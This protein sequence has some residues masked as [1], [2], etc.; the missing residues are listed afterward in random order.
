MPNV[1]WL[2][3]WRTLLSN[4]GVHIGLRIAAAAALAAVACPLIASAIRHG[5]FPRDAG[6]A[7]SQAYSWWLSGAFV[8]EPICCLVGIS[9]SAAVVRA[10]LHGDAE[11]VSTGLGDARLK[12]GSEAVRASDTWG[13]QSAPKGTGLVYGFSHGKYLFEARSPH[14][15]TVATSGAGKTRRLVAETIDLCAAAS[16]TL[17]VSD[18]KG[19][20]F[21]LMGEGLRKQ[22][23]ST[24]LIDLM[25]PACSDT[26]DPLKLCVS[27]A[28]AGDFSGMQQAAEDIAASIVPDDRQGSA[29]HWVESARGILAATIAC[30]ASTPECPDDMRKMPSACRIVDEGSERGA[31]GLKALIASLPDGNPVRALGSQILS[32]E[33]NE[34]AS[35]MS[36]L[37]VALRPYGSDAVRYVM[38][39]SDIDPAEIVGGR[40]KYALFLRIQD[41]GSPYNGVFAMLFAQIWQAAFLIADGNGGKLPRPIT[42]VG[43]EWGNL[44]RVACLPALCSLGRSLG[45]RWHGFV[46]DTGQLDKYGK[47]GKQKIL[48]NCAV[49]VALR[50]GSQ[51]DCALFTALCGKTTRHPKS[52]GS[53]RSASGQSST[54]GSGE[55]AD[56][57][58]HPWEWQTRLASRDGSIVVKMAEEGAPASHAGV[59]CAPT[60]DVT[61]TPSCDRYG[62]GTRDEEAAFRMHAQNELSVRMLEPVPSGWAP[63]WKDLPAMNA[64]EAKPAKEDEWSAYD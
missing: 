60:A 2:L 9:L 43:D 18:P 41:E 19:E 50:L 53:S 35:I 57:L 25:H 24:L 44:P 49:K 61:E 47:D 8:H 62:F 51:E 20:L 30:V 46:Q 3:H 6:E 34:L 37:K 58:I 5:Y 4:D 14:S 48:A 32:A 27:R 29:S 22:G 55:V 28:S 26:Y 63:T 56:D 16:E 42:I 40:G 64:S 13:G 31:Q 52:K 33:G 17:I 23:Y 10:A 1:C 21:E 38:S 12:R 59:I 15:I 45:I 39:G 7:L 11:T 36:T 54:A